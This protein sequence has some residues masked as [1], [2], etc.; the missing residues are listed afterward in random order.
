MHVYSRSIGALVA[1]H[2]NIALSVFA[3]AESTP[4]LVLFRRAESTGWVD[5]TAADFAALVT[6]VAKG[7]IVAGVAPGDRVILMSS[8]RFEWT[9][10]DFA[11]LACGAVSVPIYHGASR[12]QVQWIVEDSGAALA[13]VETGEQAAT[14]ATLGRLRRRSL[15]INDDAVGA[16]ISEGSTIEDSEVF[17]RVVELTAGDLASLMYTTGTTGQPKGCVLSH[18][19]MLAEVRALISAPV[20]VL[21]RP[22]RCVLAALPLSLVLGRVVSIAMFEAGVTQVH[23]SDPAT[24]DEAFAVVRPDVFVGVPQIFEDL[25]QRAA[26]IAASGCR[27]QRR[28][29]AFAQRTAV[30]YSRE[31]DD[32]GPT[33]VRRIQR[34]IAER[35]VYRKL[36]ADLGGRCQ[37]A[38]SGGA[39][40]P[41]EL[42]HFYRGVG[43]PVYEGYGLTESTAAHTVNGPG[44]HKV[45]TVGRPLAG[46]SVRISA[47][48]EI[49]LRGPAIFEG[50]WRNRKETEAAFDDGWFRTGDLGSL[51]D[52]GFLTVLGR[53]RDLIVT[54]GGRNIAPAHLEDRLRGHS[55]ISHAIVV[56]QS[57]PFP[58]VLLSLDQ[59]AFFSW[60]VFHGKNVSASAVDLAEDPDLRAE[61]REVINAVNSSVSSAAQVHK[62]AVLSRELTEADGDLTAT[63]KVK[64]FL[65]AEH[66][67]TEID[68]LY[69]CYEHVRGRVSG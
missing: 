10:L 67:A 4:D 23:W 31:L 61:L 57:K 21:A 25:A 22:G 8:T 48:G 42:A 3:H 62:F 40:L 59:E 53:A 13:L 24:V 43:M 65:V 36:R 44:E 35:L 6:G 45:G 58:S 49:Q 27:S 34:A 41:E 33:M 32:G 12:E 2:E 28:T 52:D 39:A 47:E 7:L 37:W 69:A 63:G 68:G 11:I 18:R 64:R 38:I 20:G 46:N 30:R 56:G 29:F 26:R 14:F 1:D 9:L 66:F 16:L 50:Y 17:R 15:T 19:N 55:L 54:A 51:D 60:K 5:V